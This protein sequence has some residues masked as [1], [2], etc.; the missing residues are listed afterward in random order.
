MSKLLNKPFR[1]FTVYALIIL[2]C[3]IP[4]YYWAVDRIWLNELDEHNRIVKDEVGKRLDKAGINEKDLDAVLQLWSTLQPGTTLTP[5]PAGTG[6]DSLYVIERK[7]GDETDRF[8]GLSSYITVNGRP[9]RMVVETNV[10]EAHET[11][12]V[13]ALV[14]ICFFILLVAGFIFLNKRIAK[15][16]WKPFRNTLDRLK[17]FDLAKDKDL[18]F[19][20]TDIGEFQELNDTLDKLIRKNVSVYTQQKAFIENASHE[21]QTPLAV[22]RSKIDILLQNKDI[23]TDQLQI[24]DAIE[25]PLSRMSRINKNL[26]LLAKIENSQFAGTEPINFSEA[27]EESLRLLVD[28]MQDKGLHFSTDISGPIFISCNGFLLETLINNLLTNAIRHTPAGGSVHIRLAGKT[29]SF[30]NS[31]PAMLDDRYLFERFA[32]SSG[33][34]TSSGLGLAIVKE[35]CNR[36]GWRISYSFDNNF[37][38][39]DISFP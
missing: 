13:I 33:E 27:L 21:L 5:V 2:V 1:A 8:R 32:V 37:H 28:Y 38:S 34:A 24:L 3:S 11:I 9:Y 17:T 20:K 25:I 10:E 39:F 12:A 22:L 14:T 7:T 35:I 36:Y 19:D 23:T 15:D 18:H 4:V 6:E 30:S 31:G 29:V 16:I 26:L